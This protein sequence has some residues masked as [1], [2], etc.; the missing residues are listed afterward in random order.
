MKTEQI[1]KEEGINLVDLFV[2]LLS[3]WKWYLLSLIICGSLSYYYYYKAPLVYS[4]MAT[5]MI[6]DPS[7]KN[8]AAG[9]DRFDNI[10]NKVNLTNELL[11]FRSKFIIREVIQRLHIDVDYQVKK[12][13]RLEELYANTPITV[14]FDSVMPE[15]YIAFEMTI[16]DEKN[17][18]LNKIVGVDKAK[19]SYQIASNGT[20]TLG[21]EKLK[22]HPTSMMSKAWKGQTIYVTKNPISAKVGMYRGSLGVFQDEGSSIINLSIKDS[23]GARASDFLNTLINIYN[24]QTIIDKN[25]ISVNSAKF[26]ED[27]LK[28]IEDELGGVENEILDYKLRNNIVSLA[29]TTSQYISKSSAYSDAVVEQETQM[30]VAQYVKDYLADPENNGGLIPS[31][32]GIGDAEIENQIAQYN[33]MKLKR[34]RLLADSSDENPV[35]EELNRAMHEIRQSVV[36]AVDNKIVTIDTKRKDAMQQQN[37]AQGRANDMPVKEHGM[38]SIQRQQSIK[39]SLY[40]YLLNKRE[41]NALAQTMVDNNARVIDAAEGSYMPISPVRN[42]IMLLGVLVGLAIPTVIFLFIMFMDTKVHS[43]KDVQSKTNIPFLGEIPFDPSQSKKWWEKQHEKTE[44]SSMI[45]ESFKILRTNMTFMGKKEHRMQVITFTSFN[46]GAGKTYITSNLAKSLADS[47]KRVVMVDLDVRKRTLSHMFSG[48]KHIGVT[49]FLADESLKLDDIIYPVEGCENLDVIYGG[50]SAPNPAELLL[51]NRLDEMIEELR[52]RYDYIIADNVPVGVVADATITNRIS[53]LTIFVVRSGRLDRRQI[54]DM[55]SLYQEGKL[56][57]M[58]VVL[59]GVDPKY[60]GYGYRY[61]YGYGYGY[62]YRYG[63]GYGEEKK[64]K[65]FTFKK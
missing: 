27:R 31:N 3:K 64:K 44:Q 10:V 6:K 21:G 20:L 14:E 24:E 40:M 49:N 57:N 23:N 11:Q 8:I 35:V 55:E 30:K 61:G 7:N 39:E 54:P 15:R 50:Q 17:I 63:Y 62:G 1:K 47:K 25:R 19:E 60:R 59:N 28:I 5:I 38:L 4:R 32:S 22:F 56:K 12:K 26:I 45:R 2:H 51:D 34:D 18:A 16:K 13:F 41:E 53:D 9:M 43:R 33:T 42:K 65:R 29:T 46:E 52:K 36:R 48:R 58:A 37:F